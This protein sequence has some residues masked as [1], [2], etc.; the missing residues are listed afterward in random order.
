MSQRNNI[1]PLLFSLILTL[2]LL[3]GGAWLVLRFLK[4]DVPP[5]IPL[6]TQGNDSDPSNTLPGTSQAPWPESG[7][8]NLDF[9][10]QVPAVPA[11]LFNY[12]GSTTWAP[13]R[14]DADPVI[15]AVWP[16]FRL[17]YTD[18]TSGTPG[19]GSGIRMLLNDQLVF[20]QSSRPINDSERQQAQNRGYQLEAIPVAID[21]IAL[22]VNPSLN[23]PGVTVQDVVDI[24]TGKITNWSQVGGPNLSI[25]A[26]SRRP[27]DGG[28]VEYFV[29][30]VLNGQNLGSNVELTR[31]TTD[32]L[33]K[34][35]ANPGGIYYASAPEIVGQ[36]TVRPLPLSARGSDFIPPYQS[37][38]APL[39]NCPAQRNV[40]NHGA[41]Q[42]GTYPIT[43][44]LFVII[45][46]NGQLDEQVGRTYA[47]L[48]LTNQG[49]ELIVKAGYVRLR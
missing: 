14:R 8:S 36:C 45:K 25:T 29:D 48:L 33:R 35:G 38:F 13:I 43:R 31:D 12:G 32:G 1:V 24:Y 11:G 23:I 41:F 30:E 10:A 5:G 40:L 2:G 20:S 34:V 27:E 17:R 49:Q 22:A 47:D 21:G 28:T 19:S 46:K 18:P 42:T 15:Q 6:P 7:Q 9:F 26:Y 4:S 39:E 44:R 3:G 16:N 37:P